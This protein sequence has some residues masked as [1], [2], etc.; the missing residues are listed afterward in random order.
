MKY[1][2]PLPKDAMYYSVRN[3]DEFD[4]RHPYEK[5]ESELIDLNDKTQN[6]HKT[7]NLVFYSLLVIIY[8]LWS[9]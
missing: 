2:Y 3:M 4:I 7:L 5:I 1:S 6:L 8:L 9:K